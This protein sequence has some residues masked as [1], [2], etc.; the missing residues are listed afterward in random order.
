MSILGFVIL[1]GCELFSTRSPEPP[2]GSNG[3]RWRFPS[4]PRLVVDNLSSALGRR[5]SVDYAKSFISG[6]DEAYQYQF[7]P[8]PQ[9]AADYPHFF[10]DWDVAQEQKFAQSLFNPG[11]FPLD[12]LIS[13]EMNIE[14]EV[15]I[16]DSAQISAEYALY[17]G[18]LR[19]AAPREIA[20][21]MELHLRKVIDGG[22][23]ILRWV[24]ARR[25]GHSCFSDLK[26]KF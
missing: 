6:P 5:S 8:D 21:R 3:G 25:A 14:R 11:N 16:A 22:W 26:A 20:G 19:S 7:T 23:Y 15:V 17:I 2:A 1:T 13:V 10:D 9:T 12:S 24:D 4:Q 18:H